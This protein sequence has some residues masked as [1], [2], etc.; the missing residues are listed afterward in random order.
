MI[1]ARIF[2][3]E[4][5]TGRNR[6]TDSRFFAAFR[7]I[8]RLSHALPGTK[9]ELCEDSHVAGR[10]LQQL[11][12]I[13][14]CLSLRS[15]RASPCGV[16]IDA[17][18]AARPRLLGDRQAPYRRSSDKAPGISNRRGW[19]V[20]SATWTSGAAATAAPTGIASPEAR[21]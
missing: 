21:R 7:F 19:A 16:G 5:P 4:A 6:P 10:Q 14:E 20:R 3:I 9:H 18:C 8:L 13:D 15:D 17:V 11:Q 2:V 1:T 12:F